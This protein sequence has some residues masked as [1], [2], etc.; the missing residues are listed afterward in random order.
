V[1]KTEWLRAHDPVRGI[2]TAF[3]STVL[4]LLL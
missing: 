4:T 3:H 2:V 1:R